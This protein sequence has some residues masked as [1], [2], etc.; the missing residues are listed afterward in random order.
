MTNPH[1]N[2]LTSRPA[3]LAPLLLVLALTATAGCDPAPPGDAGAVSGTETADMV[4]LDGRVVTVDPEWGEVEAVA[5]RGD[6]IVA[7]GSTEQISGL[8]GPQTEIVPLDGRLTIPGFI[9]GHGHFLGHGNARMILD[10]SGT[11]SWDELVELVAEAVS[12]TEPGS[13]ITG[14]GWHQERWES[15]GHELFDGLPS[16]HTLSQVSPENPVILTHASGHGSIANAR[17]LE[18]AGIHADT[19]DPPGGTIIRDHEGEPTGFLRQA[20]QGPVRAALARY[21]EGMTAQERRARLLRQIELAGEDALAHG[22]TSYH[23]A[24]AT[25]AEI[26]LFRE[27]AEAGNLPVRLYSAIRGE[28]MESMRQ[29]LPDYRFV[30]HANHFLTVRAIKQVIDGALGT[31]G[32]WFLEPYADNPETAGLPQT[33]P[34]DLRAVA[35][36]ALE[37][38]FQ[39]N[40]HAIGDRGNRETLDAYEEVLSVNGGVTPDH[41]WRVEHAQH[42]HPDDI[43]RFAELGVIASMQGIHGTS[44]GPWVEP[45]LGADR[46]RTG[47]YVWRD[48]LDSGATI[49]NGTDVPVEPVS[50]IASFYAS[51]SRMTPQGWRFH[52]EQ[53]MTRMEALESYTIHCAFAGFAE[54]EVGSLTPGKLADIVV[55]DR[56]ILS[57][58]EEEIPGA[59]VDLTILGGEVRYRR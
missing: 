23:D 41:R 43:S 37:H 16:H 25:F 45:R 20:A 51:V 21:E 32:A 40:T 36:L 29:Q 52:P 53:A 56:D 47:A 39:V 57:I 58:A 17:A 38:G 34:D 54:D 15:T 27:L 26:D 59:R 35:R 24:G 5:I 7:V 22:V 4:L 13:W 6:R 30:G 8:V 2:A 44:D 11:R 9:E 19:E 46:T 12:G 33:D 31:H 42:L 18:E 50:P 14:R 3:G 1:H 49:C 28:S 55:L 10:L 48:L